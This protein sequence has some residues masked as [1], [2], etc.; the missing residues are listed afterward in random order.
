KP[1]ALLKLVYRNQLFPRDAYRQTFERLLEAVGE[2]AACK[3]AV[4]R[5]SLAHER[6]CEAELAGLLAEGLAAARLPDMAALWARFAPDPA[7]LPDVVV[8]LTPL[9]D[10]DVLLVGEAA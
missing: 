1:M 8:E 2:R 4:E 6:A 3:Q 10:Y 9:T 7:A 5:L